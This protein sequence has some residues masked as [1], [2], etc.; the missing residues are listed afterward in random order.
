MKVTD[1]AH[2]LKEYM[3]LH[4]LRQVDILERVKPYCEEH[5]VKMNKSDL[6]QYV[7]GKTEPGQDKL[8]VLAKALN[9]SETWLMGYDDSTNPNPSQF[10]YKQFLEEIQSPNNSWNY[11]VPLY[12]SVKIEN[13]EIVP[14]D[15]IKWISTDDERAKNYIALLIPGKE[16]EPKY[17]NKDIALINQQSTFQDNKYFYILINGKSPTIRKV[18]FKENNTIILQ[19]DNPQIGI[20]LK[21]NNDIVVGQLISIQKIESYE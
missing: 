9:V 11:K 17:C 13:S 15:F 5:D 6:S 19:A 18:S 21:S 8:F 4:N 12:K 14:Y 2:R 16:F 3:S 20:E 7:S 10:P 1:T